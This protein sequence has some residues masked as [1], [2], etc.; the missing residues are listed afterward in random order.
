MRRFRENDQPATLSHK[1]SEGIL[2]HEKAEDMP[3][4]PVGRF[5]RMPGDDRTF[6]LACGF[7]AGGEPGS[8]LASRDHGT[9]WE[10]TGAFDPDGT[11]HPTDSGAFTCTDNGTLIA[12]FSNRAERVKETEWD[13]DLKDGP[14]W[15]LPVYA[16]RSLDGGKTWQNLQKLHDEW[17]GANRDMLQTRDG[18][19]VFTTQKLLHS[20]GRHGVLTYCS[21]DEGKTWTASN[22]ID[23]GGNGHHGGVC[24]ATLVELKDGRLLKYIR[25][26]WGQ[27]WRALS[28]DGGRHWHPYGPAGIDASS[29]PGFLERLHSGRIALAWNRYFPEGKD[30]WPLRGGDGIWSATPTSNF[31]QELSISFSQDECQTWS[32]PVVI[33]RNEGSEVSYPY[34]F[35]HEPGVLWITAGRWKLRMRLREADFIR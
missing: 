14:G 28:S 4:V 12:A 16:A 24:E 15:R 29:A 2:I 8:V 21:D 33:A 11:L 1:T 7:P 35:E 17:T 10:P 19:I 18:R 26:N 27:L 32:P 22:L 31:R 23:L 9:T 13:P 30:T 6:V 5:A 34:I 25:T 3:H 20:P